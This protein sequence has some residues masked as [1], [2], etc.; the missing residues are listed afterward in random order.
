MLRRTV[1]S[2]AFLALLSIGCGDSSGP[3]GGGTPALQ[4]MPVDS[5]FDFSVHVAA[6]PGDPNRLFIVERTGRIVL[7]KNGVRQ[8]SAFLNLTAL[9]DPSSGEYGVFSVAFHPQY[10]TNRRF[11]VYYVALDG[12]SEVVEY[13]AEP[14][15]DFAVPNPVQVILDQPQAAATVMYGGLLLFGPDDKLYVTL[16]DGH[17]YGA[18]TTAAQD[19][20]VLLGKVLRLDVDAGSPYAVP[21]DNPFVGRA[22]WRGEIFQLGLRNPWRWSFDRLTGDQWLGDV[23]EDT[24]EELNFVPAPVGGQNF[25]WPYR[26]GPDC[27]LPANGCPSNGLTMPADSYGR[28]TGCA[29]VGGYVYRGAQSDMQGVYFY[30]DYCNGEVRSARRVGSTLTEVFPPLPAPLLNDNVASFGEDAQG[31]L[32]VAMAS[33]RVYRIVSTRLSR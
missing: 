21:S 25:G 11:F 2:T 32:Y 6:P 29:I 27:F 24:W 16:G 20:T 3:G 8:D 17:V 9:T 26:E 7:R 33:G 10:S 1:A 23:G 13:Q 12:S 19:S 28:A 14:N 4:L 31:E 15:L 5:G 22:G 18:W 30:G